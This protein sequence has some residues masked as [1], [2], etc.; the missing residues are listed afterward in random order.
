MM[1]MMYP[2]RVTASYNFLGRDEEASL[3][4]YTMVSCGNDTLR[5]PWDCVVHNKTVPGSVVR[6][7][8]S[9]FLFQCINIFFSFYF[10][11]KCILQLIFYDQGYGTFCYH[12]IVTFTSS[13]YITHVL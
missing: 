7:Y 11:F 12:V 9:D 13:I 6:K 10:I 4:M 2:Y 8:R 3:S 1:V 5:L